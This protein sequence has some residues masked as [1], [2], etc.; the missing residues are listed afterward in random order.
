MK[1]SPLCLLHDS[2]KMLDHS[3]AQPL[4]TASVQSSAPKSSTFN[5]RATSLL[6]SLPPL[7]RSPSTLNTQFYSPPAQHQPYIYI[8]YNP[9][10]TQLPILSSRPSTSNTRQSLHPHSCIPKA[11][12]YSSR[13]ADAISI[14]GTY[15]PAT[16]RKSQECMD[17]KTSSDLWRDSN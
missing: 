4:P 3:L 16:Y 14:F 7:H 13:A 2:Y 12:N 15:L 11:T 8:T 9:P 1:T 5:E 17:R 10:Y 6:L